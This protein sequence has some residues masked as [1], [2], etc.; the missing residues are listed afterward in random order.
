[1]STWSH[2]IQDKLKICIYLSYNRTV[3]ILISWLLQKPSDLDLHCLHE[4]GLI[5]LYTYKYLIIYMINGSGSDSK[6]KAYTS[7]F[8]SLSTESYIKA[9][10]YFRAGKIF[11]GQV[12]CGHLLVPGQV[13]TFTFSTPLPVIILR[14]LQNLLIL[15]AIKER[16]TEPV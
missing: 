13:E 12:H 14:N 11:F 16:L 6:L 10:L 8:L 1:M 5:S 9:N 15:T 3:W 7:H 4:I 2:F